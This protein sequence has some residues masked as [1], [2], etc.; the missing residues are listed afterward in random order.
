MYRKTGACPVC[1]ARPPAEP[2][3]RD[4]TTARASST[5]E[6]LTCGS[7]VCLAAFVVGDMARKTVNELARDV[8]EECRAIEY[9][10]A[11]MARVETSQ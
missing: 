1:H 5:A 3:P 2:M 4:L 8:D 11:C 6:R 10:G 7:S 9:I